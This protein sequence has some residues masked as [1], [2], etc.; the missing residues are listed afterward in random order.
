[1]AYELRVGALEEG[2]VIM[3]LCNNPLCCNP[4]HLYQGTQ[5]ENLQHAGSYGK[6]TREVGANSKL[7]LSDEVIHDI[8]TSRLSDRALARKYDIGCHKTISRIRRANQQ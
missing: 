6:M 2:K 3:H 7:C 5:S 1:M 8:M 4:D